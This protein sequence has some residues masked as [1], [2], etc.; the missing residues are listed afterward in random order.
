MKREGRS[1]TENETQANGERGYEQSREGEWI[2]VGFSAN[3]RVFRSSEGVRSDNTE[4][5]STT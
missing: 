2:I 3:A 5:R 4:R 1:A